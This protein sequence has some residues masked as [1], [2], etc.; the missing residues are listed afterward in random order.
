MC[1]G[2]EL[3]RGKSRIRLS[4]Y[5]EGS[6]KGDRVSGLEDSLVLRALVDSTQSW[7]LLRR[8]TGCL[9]DVSWLHALLF[10]EIL[11]RGPHLGVGGCVG[12]G[13]T[14]RFG[15]LGPPP[16]SSMPLDSNVFED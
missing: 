9:R 2:K 5:L 4:D 1:V 16:S 12:L 14:V 11:P 10:A 8:T 7:L 13:H 3:L 6:R 15:A